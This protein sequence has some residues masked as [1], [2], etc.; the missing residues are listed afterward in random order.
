M[1][2]V[3]K[4]LRDEYFTGSKVG[5]YKQLK[6]EL[7]NKTKE[8]FPYTDEQYEKKLVL[9]KIIYLFYKSS[10]ISVWV[11][12]YFTDCTQSS[13]VANNISRDE[14]IKKDWLMTYKVASI[15]YN[16]NED[17]FVVNVIRKYKCTSEKFYDGLNK[18]KNNADEWEG[19]EDD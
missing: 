18:R 11:K 14:V 12:N 9:G 2:K 1:N 16:K 8:Q 19:C 3:Q 10:N 7:K 4:R 17:C 5:L 6:N 13:L 15:S